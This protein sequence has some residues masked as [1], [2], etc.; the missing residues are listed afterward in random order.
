MNGRVLVVRDS[1]ETVPCTDLELRRF[2][3]MLRKSGHLNGPD[4]SQCI[5][6]LGEDSEGELPPN[7]TVY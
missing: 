6:D 2:H 1:D 4:L 5:L 7:S 3:H